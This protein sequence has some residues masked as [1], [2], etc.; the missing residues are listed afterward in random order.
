MTPSSR[1]PP[2]IAQTSDPGQAQ[3]AA[4]Q[5]ATISSATCPEATGVPSIAFATATELP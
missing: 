5:P 4:I 2:A 1:R 3:R